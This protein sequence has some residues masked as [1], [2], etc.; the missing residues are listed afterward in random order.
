MIAHQNI[1]IQPTILILDSGMGGLSIYIAMQKISPNINYIY[2]FDN[3]AFPYGTR[4]AEFITYRVMSIIKTIRNIHHIDLVIVACNTA[5]V[6]SLTI[7]KKNFLCP[8]IGIT[9]AIKLAS[10]YTKNGVIG[11]LA[12]HQTIN[13]YY[14]L[15]L[16]KN[17]SYKYKIMLL[18]TSTLVNIAESKIYGKKIQI[19]IFYKILEPW[20]KNKQFPDT[21]V[22]GCTHF[23]LLHKELTQILPKNSHLIDSTNFIARY[24]IQ[25]LKQYTNLPIFKTFKTQQNQAYCSLNTKNIKKIRTILLLHYQFF[26]LKTLSII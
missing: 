21:I 23:S 1:Y 15:N 22:L 25:L 24:S 10:E 3:Q 5:S 26:S 8:I 19:S 18:G 2:F 11:I 12:T 7:L 17:F 6:I 20:F 16:I 9:P 4:S 13:H 14:T